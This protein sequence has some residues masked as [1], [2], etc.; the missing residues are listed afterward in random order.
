MEYKY[1]P[2]Y[3]YALILVVTFVFFSHYKSITVDKYLAIA[4]AL[5]LIVLSFDYVLI[6]NHTPLFDDNND[7]VLDE[8]IQVTEE[9]KEEDD[10]DTDDE[11][12][13]DEEIDISNLSD[14]ELEEYNK[15]QYIK[16]K[17]MLQKLEASKHVAH[18]QGY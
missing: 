16:Y 9:K 4:L 13:D 15:M 1:P 2:V 11:E 17:K 14:R 3:K 10:N 18:H 12:F 5:T 6:N 8:L 7:I